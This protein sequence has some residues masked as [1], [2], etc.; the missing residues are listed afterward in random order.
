MTGVF[1][2]LQRHLYIG[3]LRFGLGW[4]DFW[5]I[6]S[7]GISAPLFSCLLSVVSRLSWRGVPALMDTIAGV[8]RRRKIPKAIFDLDSFL[9]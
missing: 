8:F 1:S 2:C 7:C 6:V 9:S 4:V 3:E 5:E